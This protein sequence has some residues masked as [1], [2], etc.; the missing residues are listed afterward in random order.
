MASGSRMLYMSSPSTPAASLARFSP[1]WASRWV[2]ASSA[3]GANPRGYTHDAQCVTY[4]G[5]DAEYRGRQICVGSN[6]REINIADV[7]DKANPKT[8]TYGST[9]AGGMTHLGMELFNRMAGVHIEH[10]GVEPHLGRPGLEEPP[11]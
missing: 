2:A 7:T 3:A 1:S 4:T 9:G 5:P 6:E 11:W 10:V 8:V